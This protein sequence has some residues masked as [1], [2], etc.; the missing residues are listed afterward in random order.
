MHLVFITII[1][2]IFILCLA[3]VKLLLFSKGRQYLNL[4]LC[5]AIFGVIWYGIIYLLTN[6]GLIKNHPVLFN[7]GLPLYYLIAP[8]FF[9]YIRGSL[10]PDYAVFRL[11]YLLHLVVVIPALVAIVPYSFADTATQQWVVN[12][13]D[14]DV[15][16]AFS[17]NRYIVPNWHWFTFPLS[18]LLYTLAQF[19]FAIG[20]AKTKKYEKKTLTWVLAF[21]VIC[22]I[23]FFGMLAVN[24]SVLSNFND[25]WRILHSGRLVL[26]LGLAM[27]ALS[28]SF[29]LSP[30][31]IFGFVRLK[32]AS[33]AR[34]AEARS[35]RLE[36]ELHENRVKMYDTSL[37]VRV[38]KYI[39][40]AEVFRKTGLTVSDLASMLE[41]PNHK[42][43]D[44]FNNHYKLNFNTYINNLRVHYVKGRLD[45][46]EWKQFTLEA[47]AQ[48]AGFSSRNTFLIAFKRIMGVTPS[49]YLTSLKDKAA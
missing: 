10:Q 32:P 14:K 34:T 3:I 4:L 21:T 18:A 28:G 16:F 12:Q 27:L 23:I 31:L 7:K 24:L 6:S 49:N 5:I 48:E 29:F 15:A 30:S 42:L 26:F 40:Q 9:L 13:I 43:S 8:C 1:G 37:I 45:A 38:E 11:K 44:L 36:G 2:S 41:I 20:Y 17:N 46:G 33:Q 35:G 19:S 39:L 22:G 47:I 25:I